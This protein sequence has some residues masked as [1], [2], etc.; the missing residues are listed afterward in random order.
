MVLKGELPGTTGGVLPVHIPARPG[1]THFRESVSQNVMYPLPLLLIQ[2][3]TIILFA[4][5]FGYIC[6]KIGQPAVIGDIFAGIVL[7]PS[8]L[9]LLMPHVTSFI[10]PSGSLSTLHYF[11]QIGL[12]DEMSSA[13]E[14]F[15]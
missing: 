8:V 10:F 2:I 7:A 15:M 1:L 4:T 11:S 13:L 3:I 14:D 5:V 12:R 9:G 6:R